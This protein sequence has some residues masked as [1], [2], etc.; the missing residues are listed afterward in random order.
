MDEGIRASRVGLF[1]GAL[2]AIGVTVN[3]KQR[4]K[5]EEYLFTRNRGRYVARKVHVGVS[6]HGRIRHWYNENQSQ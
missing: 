6:Q 1:P 5:T 2:G 4:S 3:V